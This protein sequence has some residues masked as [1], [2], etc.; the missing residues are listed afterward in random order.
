MATE[1]A[2]LGG[3]C[4]WCLEAAFQEVKGVDRV[5]SGYSGGTVE[6]PTYELVSSGI[7]GH[8]EVIGVR[9]DSDLLGYA[10]VLRIFFAL[11]DPTTPDRQ[12]ND[13]G[14]QYR[15]IIFYH[16]PDQERIAREVLAEVEKEWSLPVVTRLEPF[17]KFHPAEDFLQ[18]YFKNFPEETYCTLVIRPKMA[19]FRKRYANYLKA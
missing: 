7:T 17:T 6:N 13:V 4:F 12:G 19:S 10:D 3:G 9:F 2:T 5:V 8:A 1:Y 15:S 14:T 18:N 11:H 16:T